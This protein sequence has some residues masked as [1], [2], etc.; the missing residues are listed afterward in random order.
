MHRYMPAP[1]LQLLSNTDRHNLTKLAIKTR[2]KQRNNSTSCHKARIISFLLCC[3]TK[4]SHSFS[5]IYHLI[6]YNSQFSSLNKGR[7][8]ID[9]T[10]TAKDRERH[11]LKSC[12]F[13]SSA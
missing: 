13:F 10:D 1:P 2:H 7:T 8:D 6:F 12:P 3:Q 9:K 4:H 11:V 5:C